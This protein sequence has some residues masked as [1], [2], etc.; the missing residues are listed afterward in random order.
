MKKAFFEI[1]DEMRTARGRN[2]KKIK[3][4]VLRKYSHIILKDFVA[5]AVNPNIK[6]LVDTSDI[7]FRKADGINMEEE[8]YNKVRM[9]P[10]LV[11]VNGHVVKPSIKDHKRQ[12]IFIDILETVHPRDADI[13]ID[14]VDGKLPFDEEVVR[15]AFPDLLTYK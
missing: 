15:E 1:I 11:S 2:A 7:K 8:M 12:D 10:N 3:A 14:L 9:F 6:F 13:I 4:E 5:Y